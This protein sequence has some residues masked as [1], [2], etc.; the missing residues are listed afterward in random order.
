MSNKEKRLKNLN[1]LS[2]LALMAKADDSFDKKEQEFYFFMADKLN[3]GPV[4]AKKLLDH[5]EDV[6]LKNPRFLD[7]RKQVLTDVLTIMVAN[8]VIDDQELALCRKFAEFM[9]FDT[10]VVEKV[11]A[12]LLEYSKGELDRK[13]ITKILDEL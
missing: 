4:T 5:P 6:Q 8:K 7:H 13:E 11:A 10:E 2:Y 9:N 1:H 3:I 12:S